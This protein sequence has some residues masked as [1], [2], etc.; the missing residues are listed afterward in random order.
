MRAD[1]ILDGNVLAADRFVGDGDRRRIRKRRSKLKVLK[2]VNRPSAA[3][4][5]RCAVGR[6]LGHV[7]N[8]IF[9]KPAVEDLLSVFCHR[10]ET[11]VFQEL[12][13]LSEISV[14]VS[15]IHQMI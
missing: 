5:D 11:K 14:P 10:Y 15:H 6:L 2:T 4:Q 3:Q 8:R 9:A 7:G 1:W 12:M 13:C